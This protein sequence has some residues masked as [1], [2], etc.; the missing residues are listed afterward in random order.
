M[1]PERIAA[2][3]AI[4]KEGVRTDRPMKNFMNIYDA[5]NGLSEALD[6]IERVRAKIKVLS[7]YNLKTDDYT[8]NAERELLAALEGV[9]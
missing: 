1:T 2:L 9:R 6:A 8:I 3:R 7:L 4:L 5:A